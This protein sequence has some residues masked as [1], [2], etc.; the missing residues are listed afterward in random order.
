MGVQKDRYQGMNERDRIAFVES[1]D[2]VDAAK[3]FAIQ[4]LAA[5]EDAATRQ[6]KYFDSILLLREY[7]RG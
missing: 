6:S 1:R 3:K 5:Y 4:T 7:I 2:G